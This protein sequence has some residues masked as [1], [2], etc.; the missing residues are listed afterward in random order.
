MLVLNDRTHKQKEIA[1]CAWLVMIT[2]KSCCMQEASQCGAVQ[3]LANKSSSLVYQS[4]L[5]LL[6]SFVLMHTTATT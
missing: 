1:N 4:P 3:T 2:V 6:Q 5:P